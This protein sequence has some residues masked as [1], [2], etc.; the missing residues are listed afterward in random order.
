M[1]QTITVA[2]NEIISLELIDGVAHINGMTVADVFKKHE[3]APDPSRFLVQKG[4]KEKSWCGCL[5]GVIACEVKG[6]PKNAQSDEFFL[7]DKYVSDITELSEDSLSMAERGF[8][9]SSGAF[10][11]FTPRDDPFWIFGAS[12]WNQLGIKLE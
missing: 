2:K 3:L 11:K 8:M 1:S 10:G 5:L 7:Y 6:S 9:K 12:A 4:L